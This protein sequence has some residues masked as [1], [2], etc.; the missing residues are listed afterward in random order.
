MRRTLLWL[1][2]LFLVWRGWVYLYSRP[3]FWAWLA[4]ASARASVGACDLY[5]RTKREQGQR[6]TQALAGPAA[7][8]Q[9][10]TEPLDADSVLDDIRYFL[11]KGR[12]R[13]A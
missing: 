3:H 11:Q 8:A 2:A 7:R 12:W 9:T 5:Q 4:K 6:D 13:G 1:F 10:A